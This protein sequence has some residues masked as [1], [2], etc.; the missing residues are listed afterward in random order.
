VQAPP[1]SGENDPPTYTA[2]ITLPYTPIPGTAGKFETSAEGVSDT[3]PYV[4]CDGDTIYYD[5]PQ[6]PKVAN[7][8]VDSNSNGPGTA[9]FNWTI[10]PYLWPTDDNLTYCDCAGCSSSCTTSGVDDP[11]QVI[12]IAQPS[13]AFTQVVDCS[14][15]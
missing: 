5:P 1:A 4:D 9:Q 10:T 15:N 6:A 13:K 3:S 12:P 7:G 2:S 11:S 14:S 8:A